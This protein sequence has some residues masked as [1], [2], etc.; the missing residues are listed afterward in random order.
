M[1]LYIEIIKNVFKSGLTYRFNYFTGLIGKIL[2]IYA[3]YF[4]WK[5]LLMDKIVDTSF[6][7]IDFPN[8][9]TYIIISSII[10]TI[11]SNNVIM[12]VN[13][14]IDN[15]KIALDFIKPINFQ[16]YMFCNTIG[17]NLYEVLFNLIPVTIVSIIVFD[18]QFPEIIYFILFLIAIIGGFL[19]NYFLSFCLGLLGF[20]FTQVWILGRV[21]ND[22]IK[23]FAGVYIPLWFFPVILE[24][25]L[26]YLPFKFIYFVPI[27]IFLGKYNLL[28]CLLMFLMQLI[29]III[30]YFLSKIIW[31]KAIYKLVVQG[32]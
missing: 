12:D 27:S 11:T 10:S 21:L 26:D 28:E 29:W 6:G 31:K 13:N 1:K 8:M 15:G 32:G 30:L 16:L 25:I 24:S 9:V 3:Q 14:S 4:I 17:K 18:I 7:T 22:L 20:W 23:L 5:A 2:Y 19:I